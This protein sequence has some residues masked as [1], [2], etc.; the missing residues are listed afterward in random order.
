[1]KSTSGKT[2]CHDDQVAHD[3][4]KKTGFPGELA[5]RLAALHTEGKHED[6]PPRPPDESESDP[7]D[8]TEYLAC[9]PKP[10]SLGAYTGLGDAS[11]A[12]AFGI[13]AGVFGGLMGH[14]LAEELYER[15]H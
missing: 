4:I 14:L 2:P 8:D 7:D 15:T 1:M 11:G 5:K 13:A 6:A 9:E 12:P 3:L 10:L